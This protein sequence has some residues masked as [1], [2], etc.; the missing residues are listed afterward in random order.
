MADKRGHT[1]YNLG[2]Y[3]VFEKNIDLEQTDMMLANLGLGGAFI[4]TDKPAV[5]GSTVTLRFYLP[6][7]SVP[8]SVS[9]EVAWWQTDPSKG[10]VG[11]GVKFTAVNEKDLEDIKRYLEQLVAEELFG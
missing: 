9:G 11:M 4:K 2:I 3:G 8:I 7:R 5:P 10:N 6:G 1:R